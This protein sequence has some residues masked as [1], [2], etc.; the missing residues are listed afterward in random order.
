MFHWGFIPASSRGRDKHFLRGSFLQSPNT[1]RH[2]PA[3]LDV[4]HGPLLTFFVHASKKKKIVMFGWCTASHSTSGSRRHS[5]PPITR[6]GVSGLHMPIGMAPVSLP[7]CIYDSTLLLSSL[8]S[9]HGSMLCMLYPRPR[10]PNVRAPS[11]VTPSS[12][13]N[14]ERS[15]APIMSPKDARPYSHLCGAAAVQI[16]REKKTRKQDGIK[17]RPVPFSSPSIFCFIY[18]Y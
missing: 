1:H 17:K 14:L 16:G 13:K 9:I 7:R 2:A 6:H 5:F 18:I 10:A 8:N 4:D 11:A 15:P 3:G 12:I